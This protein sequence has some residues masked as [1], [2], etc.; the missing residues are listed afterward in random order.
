M[1]ALT[2]ALA[3]AMAVAFTGCSNLRCR[4]LPPKPCMSA[5]TCPAPCPPAKVCKKTCEK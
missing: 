1:K 4:T 3:V 2:I 5:Q